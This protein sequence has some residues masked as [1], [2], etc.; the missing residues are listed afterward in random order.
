MALNTQNSLP[1]PTKAKTYGVYGTISPLASASST[2]LFTVASNQTLKIEDGNFAI[3]W[4]ETS[5]LEACYVQVNLIIGGTRLPLYETRVE[6]NATGEYFFNLK[7]VILSPITLKTGDAVKIEFVY[8]FELGGA[9]VG[10]IDGYITSAILV[11]DYQ[12]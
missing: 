2:T 12:A 7:D 9:N 1:N 11:N 6:A 5:G 8:D 3:K 10:I 4:L